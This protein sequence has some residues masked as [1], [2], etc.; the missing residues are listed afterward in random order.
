MPV[1]QHQ[2]IY[3]TLEDKFQII[4]MVSLVRNIGLDGSG[5]SMPQNNKT[6]QTLYDS[7]PTSDDNHFE[8]VGTGWECYDYNKQ[9]YIK[10]RNWQDRRYYA[11]HFFKKVARLIKYR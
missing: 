8:F 10:E 4:P 1:D 11:I 6:I 5:G 9:L 7:I 3:M 2:A